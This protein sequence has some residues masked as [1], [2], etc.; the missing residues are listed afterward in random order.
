[1]K[2]LEPPHTELCSAEYTATL[3][4]GLDGPEHIYITAQGMHPTSGYKIIFRTEPE[5]VY[6]PEFSLWHIR[7]TGFVSQMVTPFTETTIFEVRGTVEREC[8]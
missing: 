5:D 2:K 8:S 6:P 4:P 7:P 1:M 3:V